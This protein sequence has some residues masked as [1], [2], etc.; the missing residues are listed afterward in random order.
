MIW[1]R[2]LLLVARRI[3]KDPWSQSGGMEPNKAKSSFFHPTRHAPMNGSHNVTSYEPSI[4]TQASQQPITADGSDFNFDGKQG[5]IRNVPPI[6]CYSY[7]NTGFSVA[8]R[9]HGTHTADQVAYGTRASIGT[10]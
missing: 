1:L 2:A 7:A 6:C 4:V 10:L 3:D 5:S 8:H 9:T